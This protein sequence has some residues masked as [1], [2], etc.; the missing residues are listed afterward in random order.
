MLSAMFAFARPIY[1]TFYYYVGEIPYTELYSGDFVV[2]NGDPEWKG[3]NSVSWF[4]PAGQYSMSIELSAPNGSFG[5][6]A[7][8][9]QDPLPNS[10]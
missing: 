4:L 9:S 7:I 8:P 10:A 1:Y 6:V 5:A 3:L 2:T